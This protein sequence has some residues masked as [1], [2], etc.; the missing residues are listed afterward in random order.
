M[1]LFGEKY[2]D[3]VRMVSMGNFSKELC[4]GTHL[5]R[6][7]QVGLFEII[8][9]EGISAGTRRVVALTGQRADEHRQQ[10]VAAL[11][12]AAEI[13]QV[14]TDQVDTAAEML[15]ARLRGLK[16]QLAGGDGSQT[17]AAEAETAASPDT[18]YSAQ[19]AIIKR[20]ARQLNVP[21]F[22]IPQRLRSMR[23]EC[24]LVEQQ[25]AE[26]ERAGGMSADELI[27]GAEEIAGAKVIVAE[28]PMAASNLMR[29]LI[30]QIRKSV[31]P[32][33]VLLAAREGDDKVTLVAGLSRELVDR[34]ISAGS[35][36]KEVAGVVGGG[37]G[38]RPDMAQAGG[39]IP[40]KTPEALE[41]AT[42]WITAALA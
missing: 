6:T 25:L 13:L 7:D 3:P 28:L 22:Q 39:K 12:E 32:S 23:E 42:E 20:V 10:T 8:S 1:M 2:P 33:A 31:A 5:T 14:K 27:A 18:S 17:K 11:E 19:R 40:A 24:E 37:G 9:E 36:V 38:G 4:G 29:Q 16:K 30:D 35:W 34:K 21:M 15:V 26:R 41:R